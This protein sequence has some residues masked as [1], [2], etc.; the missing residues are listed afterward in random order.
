MRHRPLGIAPGL[1]AGRR[2]FGDPILS[3]I[4]S[5]TGSLSSA[6]TGAWDTLAVPALNLMERAGGAVWRGFTTTITWLWELIAPLR[7]AADWAWQGLCRLF[8]IA[9]NST[10]DI[11]QSLAGFAERAWTALQASI[12]P[13]R[14]PLMV[15]GGIL[16]MITPG[17]QVLI[18]SQIIP[19]V[20]D[21]ISWLVQ[22]WRSIGIVVEAREI[23]HKELQRAMVED[24][25]E[26]D[27]A[28]RIKQLEKQMLEHARNLEFEKA[29][30]VRDQLALLKEQAF[31]AAVHDNVVPIVARK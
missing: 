24:L 26:K 25:S 27:V 2:Q 7:E 10:S 20:Y 9:W 21:K 14:T 31:G 13:I 30:R 16:L 1:I 11:R 19:S 23:L 8:R 6:C 15:L 22:N 3:F 12:A 28:K 5:A 18:L 4:E 29:A 17:G